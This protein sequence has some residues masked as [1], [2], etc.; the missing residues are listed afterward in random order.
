M[1]LTP[2]MGDRGWGR[3][4]LALWRLPAISENQGKAIGKGLSE[5]GDA[6][7]LPGVA[8]AI[9]LGGTPKAP[10]KAR[11]MSKPFA[12]CPDMR[13]ESTARM[14]CP[15]GW[16]GRLVGNSFGASFADPYQCSKARDY[17]V[18]LGWKH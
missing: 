13:S 2:K 4:G 17:Q 5:D 7:Q 3:E 6:V 16:I 1:I 15:R 12:V 10:G 18:P 8:K 9:N 14:E 11:A